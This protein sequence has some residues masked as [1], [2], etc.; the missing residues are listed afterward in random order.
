M[1]AWLDVSVC[2]CARACTHYKA[3]GEDDRKF[4]SLPPSLPRSSNGLILRLTPHGTNVTNPKTSP[5]DI[6]T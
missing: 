4:L 5:V 1:G 2:V 6:G 3:E